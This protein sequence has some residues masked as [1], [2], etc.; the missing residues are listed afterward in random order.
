MLRSLLQVNKVY[1]STAS[2]ALCVETAIIAVYQ[3]NEFS[4]YQKKK[5]RKNTPLEKFSFLIHVC[6]MPA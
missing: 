6:G 5:E 4:Y 1:H 2:F 3:Q